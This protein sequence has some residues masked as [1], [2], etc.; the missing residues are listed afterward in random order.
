MEETAKDHLEHAEHAGHAAAEGNPFLITVS[1]TIAALAVAA[2]IVAS[3]EAIETSETIGEKNAAVLKQS[4]ASDQW[5]FFQAKS[6]K[7]KMIEIAAASGTHPKAA[8]M[9]REA[10]R[11]EA[12]NEEIEKKAHELE[13]ERDEALAAA[14]K[15]EKRHHGLTIAATLIHVAIA[16]C[17]VSV[18]T[19]GQR[20]PWQTALGLAALGVVKAI[21]VY[22]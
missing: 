2:A 15:H 1:A 4:Q 7:H 16:I 14:V 19:R 3:I 13:H 6:L 10:Q 11:Y 22:M 9:T 8:D 12:E 17:T 20:W 18:I 5:A 21:S